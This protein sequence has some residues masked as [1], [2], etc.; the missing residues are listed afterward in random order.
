MADDNVKNMRSD[1]EQK[2]LVMARGWLSSPWF[3]LIRLVALGVSVSLAGYFLFKT[4]DTPYIAILNGTD[5]YAAITQSTVFSEH[6]L[7]ASTYYLVWPQSRRTAMDELEQG[8]RQRIK[9]DVLREDVSEA[10]LTLRQYGDEH[11]FKPTLSELMFRNMA[12]FLS[13]GASGA[14]LLAWVLLERRRKQAPSSGSGGGQ[15]AAAEK[16]EAERAAARKA[17]D[18]R[19]ARE[20][21]EKAEAERKAEM[22]LP[23]IPPEP[24]QRIE[25]VAIPGGTFWMGTAKSDRVISVLEQPVH[26]VTLSPFELAKCPVTRGLYRDVVGTDPST[27][28]QGDKLPVTDVSW[29]DAVRFCNALSKREGLA[30]AYRIEG[31]TVWWLDQVGGETADGANGYRLPTEAEWEFAARSA[32]DW[33]YPWGNEP[34]DDQACWSGMKRREGPCPVGSFPTGASPFGL[35]DMAGNVNEWC[36]DSFGPYK[37]GGRR[38]PR[39]PESGSERVSR[40]GS[41]K[42]SNAIHLR[43]SDRR[44][45]AETSR[46]A[47]IGFRCART[48]DPATKLFGEP[49]AQKPKSAPLESAKQAEDGQRA[50]E[51]HEVERGV[52]AAEDAET[53]RK[54]EARGEENSDQIQIAKKDLIAARLAAAFASQVGTGVMRAGELVPRVLHDFELR[55]Q[56]SDL[57]YRLN[58]MSLSSKDPEEYLPEA[59]PIAEVLPICV[60]AD[61]V[62]HAV[63]KV[64]VH[65]FTAPRDAGPLS[66]YARCGREIWALAKGEMAQEDSKEITSL[67]NQAASGDL[68]AQ[69]H[70]ALSLFNGDGVRLRK[71]SEALTLLTDAA[72]R[73][74][75]G[76]QVNLG[77]MYQDG[78]FGIIDNAKAEPWLRKAAEQGSK[79][80][81]DRLARRR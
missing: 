70:L 50:R 79:N 33:I 9:R 71:L 6:D 11:G 66:R 18:A 45:L 54:E 31:D 26:E 30:P 56:I 78:N 3:R 68:E 23:V 32:N 67:R 80:A 48:H 49:S 75:R 59:G 38:D 47:F 40:G 42:L 41:W 20:A 35:L 22:K 53:E 15:K 34:P 72:E 14:I 44:N 65:F 17:E 28:G 16:A 57:L 21:A 64:F 55:L 24:T 76:S 25:M 4:E 7:S 10:L 13:F 19:L 29:I 43:A 46:T 61:D 52:G 12:L 5:S 81:K 27:V 60:S 63:H 36:W 39:G 69:M 1:A 62:T 58:P 51:I 77:C 37:S 73:G 74:H 2:A 8:L